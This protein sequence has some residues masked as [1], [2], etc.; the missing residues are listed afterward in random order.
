MREQINFNVEYNTFSA[1]KIEEL[2]ARTK[3]SIPGTFEKE[4]D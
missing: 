2:G 4:S 1:K 3:K